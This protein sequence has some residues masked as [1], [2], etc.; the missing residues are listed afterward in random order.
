VR[1]WLGALAALAIGCAG[2][3]SPR[4]TA[5]RVSAARQLVGGP[6]ALG[7][8]GDYVLENDQIRVIVHGPGPGRGS[9]L[10]GGSIIDADLQRP[11]GNA[12][13]GNDQLGEV[14]PSY[15]LEGMNPVSMSVTASGA[16]GGPAAVTVVGVGADLL[17]QVA[18]LNQGIL[19]PASLEMTE[20]YKLSPGKRYVEITTTIRNT[21]SIPHPLPYLQPPELRDLGLDIP[22][23][24]DLAL[25]VPIGHLMLFGREN[26]L[27]AMG[28]TG[29][30]VRFG[31]EDSYDL[32]QGFPAFPGLVT[33]LL[34]TRG[35]G[36][37]YGLAVP[38]SSDNYP[39]VFGSL[40]EPQRVTAHSL[41]IPYLY[42]AVCGV[43]HTN[44]PDALL[45]GERFSTTAWL[46]VGR[47][48]VASVTDVV[49]ELRGETTGS[50]AGRVLDELT[51]A[52]IERASV[53]VRNGT[54]WITQADSDAG[55]V[56][57]MSLP[58]GDYQYTVVTP[59]RKPTAMEN[60][61][62]E[63]G[64]TTS[65]RI[66]LRPPGRIAVFVRDEVGRPVPAKVQLV[67]RFDAAHLGEDPRTFLYDLSM[68]ERSRT[69]TLDP[70][71]TEFIENSWYVAA[72]VL[73]AEV[74]PGAYDLVVSRGVEYDLLSVPVV[75]SEGAFVT[76][77]VQLRRAF[78]TD[79]Y[80]ATD[81]HLHA[82]NSV[83][84]DLPIVDRVISV[85]GEGVEFAAATDHNFVTDY[86]AAIREAGLESWLRAVAG[87]ELTTFEMGHF[88]GYPL[89]LDPGNVRGGQFEWV[90]LTPDQLFDQLRGMG[91]RPEDVIVQVNHP[92]DGVLG[93]FTQFNVDT[94]TG[95]PTPRLGLS[96][97][98]AP[99][100]P[101]FAL[102]N[103]SYDFD[104]IEVYNG[105]RREL[106]HHFV[107][108]DPLPPPPLPENPP[109]PGEI[110]RTDE[111]RIAFPGQVDDWFTLL[112]R[113]LSPTAV[114]NSDSHGLLG[115][116][117]GYAR[118]WVWVGSGRDTANR[119]ADDDVI[120]GLRA[121][122][123]I[124]SNA[125][126]VELTVE[127]APIGALVGTGATARAVVKVRSARFAPVTK[128]RLWQ[129]GVVVHEAD[130]P[131]ARANAYDTEVD[132]AV[133]EDAWVVAEVTG[134]ANM[135]PVVPPQEFEPV[136]VD[137]VLEAIG[138]GL[139]LSGLSPTGNLKPSRTYPAT[140]SAMTNPIWL[141][142][143]GD[144]EFDPPLP[145]LT[146]KRSQKRVVPDVRDAF[147][148]VQ[149]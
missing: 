12:G 10:Y 1:A 53:L 27:F 3:D 8:I 129:N 77:A 18:I 128:L 52:P 98:L 69:T 119:Y 25:S 120:A 78:S 58:P 39:Q 117:P 118:S 30:N 5:D 70:T 71:R 47:G 13:R 48:D 46:I 7:Q 56:F 135:F 61:V 144:G 45:P 55:G 136:S 83:D 4:A 41:V 2:N 101:E 115:D 113:G 134:E 36:V 54:G 9:T 103:F 66:H 112:S 60:L 76:S 111:G 130:I 131:A 49:Y 29:F 33:E 57:K 16:D 14:L 51:G 28:P 37:S 19:F 50:F 149:E 90:G 88:N 99:F 107:A 80:V 92:R 141:D 126:F 133:D 6:K 123:A 43:F 65:R 105:K 59:S 89:A 146:R 114:G 35:R 102:E 124:V 121:H 38:S 142:R 109:A 20:E 23:L 62:V 44:P 143:D 132:L 72:G 74:V 96:A 122:R 104:T 97:V 147:R 42:A 63:A 73:V 15:L 125:P 106:I 93:Y 82:A 140:P 75:V 31:I 79:G 32:A 34:A 116:E 64:T 17:Q 138:S 145:R 67:G 26:E 94:E 86:D 95:E 127:G 81:L 24:D 137:A 100:Q 87:I 68:G 85:A 148:A 91:K 40:Y 110:V 22:G 108:P 11:E 84:S 139:D 21:T